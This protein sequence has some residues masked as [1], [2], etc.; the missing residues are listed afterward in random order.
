MV[1][2]SIVYIAKFR[3]KRSIFFTVSEI[4]R[5]RSGIF[6]FFLR[7]HLWLKRFR[8]CQKKRPHARMCLYSSISEPARKL[9]N[10]TRPTDNESTPHAS[11]QS[12]A[13]ACRQ[14]VAVVTAR[15]AKPQIQGSISLGCSFQ[16]CL[17][18]PQGDA[19]KFRNG[20]SPRIPLGFDPRKGCIDGVSTV[21]AIELHDEEPEP[22]GGSPSTRECQMIQKSFVFLD[23]LLYTQLKWS[24]RKKQSKNSFGPPKRLCLLHNFLQ[25][26]QQIYYSSS[27]LW[28]VY[29]SYN[30]VQ[31]T[32]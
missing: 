17:S 8:A 32:N 12:S 23:V 28:V 16:N 31:K 22:T 24:P 11:P 1:I 15:L 29:Y 3:R 18:Q 21:I 7:L 10:K 19:A 20:R 2:T 27:L 6:D 9:Q 30:D 14:R 5:E 26:K 4:L 25:Q 13:Q